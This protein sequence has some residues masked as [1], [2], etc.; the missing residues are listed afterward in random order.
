MS[1]QNLNWATL[2]TC[3]IANKLAQ[4][5]EAQGRKLY[6]VVNRTY[7]KGVAFAEKYGIEKVRGTFSTRAKN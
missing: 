3:V 7:E 4:T 1:K 6:S 2:E 5:L